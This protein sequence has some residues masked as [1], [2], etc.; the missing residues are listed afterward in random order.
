[1]NTLNNIIHRI[2]YF[3]IIIFI[4]LTFNI[5]FSKERFESNTDNIDIDYFVI[6]MNKPNRLESIQRQLDKVQTK[7]TD[8]NDKTEFI[9]VDAVVGMDLN[10]PELIANNQISKDYSGN[11]EQDSKQRRGEYGCY[12][13]HLKVYNLIKEHNHPGY[14]VVFEDDFDI[15]TDDFVIKMAKITETIND[16][17]PDFDLLYLGTNYEN[18]GELIKDDIYKIDKGSNLFGAHAILVNN[19]SIDKI[20]QN[21]QI[22]KV[23]IDVALQELCFDDKLTGLIIYPNIVSQ[24]FDKLDSTIT[25]FRTRSGFRTMR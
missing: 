10:L 3:L 14:S 20:I 18:H 9:V 17:N 21:T 16:Y 6:S 11:G 1:M 22:I 5:I 4:S 25:G 13:S 7:T 23:P 15:K 24:Q 12:M 19:K 2:V 8:P